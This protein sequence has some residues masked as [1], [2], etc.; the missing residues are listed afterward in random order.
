MIYEMKFD[1]RP[2]R[3]QEEVYKRIVN[4]DGN[5]VQ[6][7]EVKDCRCDKRRERMREVTREELIEWAATMTAALAAAAASGGGRRPPE[8]QPAHVSTGLALLAAVA[9]GV[10]AVAALPVEVPAGIAA[11]FVLMFGA[12]AATQ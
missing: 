7:I 2:N 3:E 10:V 6:V 9:L 5:R 4:G 1:E 11:F 8:L 12:T